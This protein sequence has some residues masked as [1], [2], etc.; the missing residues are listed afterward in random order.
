MSARGP[1]PT[2]QQ[3][4]ADA[5]AVA[6]GSP[7]QPAVTGVGMGMGMGPRPGLAWENQPEAPDSVSRA[8]ASAVALGPS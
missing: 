1:P 6:G 4:I 2:H 3:V 8:L 7:A 5:A